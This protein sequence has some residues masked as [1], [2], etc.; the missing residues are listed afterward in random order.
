[1]KTLSDKI[2]YNGLNDNVAGDWK[3]EDFAV[4]RRRDVKEFIKDIE[5]II[6]ESHSVIEMLERL[7]KKAGGKLI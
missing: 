6:V 5:V 1:M 2:V 7:K 3:T 4:I